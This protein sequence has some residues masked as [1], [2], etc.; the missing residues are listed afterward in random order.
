MF[1]IF[2]E[3][4]RSAIGSQPVLTRSLSSEILRKVFEKYVQQGVTTVVF[5]FVRQPPNS[6][7]PDMTLLMEWLSAATGVEQSMRRIQMTAEEFTEEMDKREITL[8]V[9]KGMAFAQYYPNPLHRECGDLDC[10]MMG[11]KEE[12]DK[13]TVELSGVMEEAGYKRKPITAGW[14]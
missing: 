1:P 13:I 5:D 2:L 6:E 12:G 11:K 8:V 4:L 7:A 3:I 10:Y 14:S 9:L